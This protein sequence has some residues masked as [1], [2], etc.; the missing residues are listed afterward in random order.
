[1]L[2]ACSDIHGNFEAYMKVINKLSENDKLYNI[3]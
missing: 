1:M 2:F 3:A